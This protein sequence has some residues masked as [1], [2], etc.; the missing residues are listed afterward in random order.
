[1]NIEVHSADSLTHASSRSRGRAAH[2]AIA[3]QSDP[4]LASDA[5][6]HALPGPC[7]TG[8][9][10]ALS[11]LRASYAV[12]EARLAAHLTRGRA[13]QPNPVQI[14]ARHAQ[15]MSMSMH[16]RTHVRSFCRETTRQN[17]AR[18]SDGNRD[19]VSEVRA[20]AGS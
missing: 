17:G 8:A 14:H 9:R 12:V 19:K 7:S 18:G 16:A 6:A 5:A 13:S 15:S 10:P 2:G 11:V 3:E 4:S 20:P 1:M